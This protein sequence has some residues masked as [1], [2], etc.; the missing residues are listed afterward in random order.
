[1]DLASSDPKQEAVAFEIMDP[2]TNYK[3][4]CV[5]DKGN[6]MKIWVYGY[7]SDMAID[8]RRRM[9]NQNKGKPLPSFDAKRR[10][11]A[12]LLSECIS[13]TENLYWRGKYLDDEF[14]EIRKFLLAREDIKEKLDVF[15][16][17]QQNFLSG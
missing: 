14:P 9:Q 13:H 2:A 4:P 6:T 5:D 11:E 7:Y 10:L 3:E 15:W 16:A 12:Q 17:D 8:A 1:M